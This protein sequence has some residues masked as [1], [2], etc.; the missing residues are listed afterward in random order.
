M[1][2][3]PP[4]FAKDAI[5][6]PSGWRHPRTGEILKSGKI[7]QIDIDEYYQAKT[8]APDPT[9][10]REAPVSTAEVIEEYF[11][12]YTKM[13]KSE[14]VD[15]AAEYGIELNNSMTKSEMIEIMEEY[16]LED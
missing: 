15:F 5:P 13:N 2:I 16:E 10:L 8:G 11:D 9:V 3:T 12:D 4:N 1:A 6:T 7:K 14:L